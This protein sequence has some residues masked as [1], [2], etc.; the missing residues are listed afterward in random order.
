M[1][2]AIL[3]AWW[4]VAWTYSGSGFGYQ[5]VIA[6]PF[7]TVAAC[8]TIKKEIK[9]LRLTSADCVSDGG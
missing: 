9:G 1:R 5:P 8:E 6:G 7:A 2:P 4:L 3:L